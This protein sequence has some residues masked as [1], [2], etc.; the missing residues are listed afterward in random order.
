MAPD[1]FVYPSARRIMLAESPN[2]APTP[3][4]GIE[5]SPSARRITQL[6]P[7]WRDHALGLNL[8]PDPSVQASAWSKIAR[9]TR[10]AIVI[11]LGGRVAARFGAGNLEPLTWKTVETIG[12]FV[13][14]LKFPHPSGRSRWWNRPGNTDRAR[15]ALVE[16]LSR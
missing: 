13:D 1:D 14:L 12:W 5:K 15:K 3:F 6:V 16:A 2:G 11:A 7:D 9:E 10:C 4:F 8:W